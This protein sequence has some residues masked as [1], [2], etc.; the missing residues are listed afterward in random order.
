MKSIL[1]H[2]KI[3]LPIMWGKQCS[4]DLSRPDC[5]VIGPQSSPNAIWCKIVQ[6]RHI[7]SMAKEQCLRTYGSASEQD[8]SIPNQVCREFFPT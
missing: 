3:V 1:R 8:C 7:V 5:S 6:M 4:L 2:V